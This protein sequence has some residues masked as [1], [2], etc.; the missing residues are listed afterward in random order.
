MSS[1]W[2]RTMCINYKLG[3][4]LICICAFSECFKSFF[5]FLNGYY[6]KYTKYNLETSVSFTV[7]YPSKKFYVGF[8]GGKSATTC[9]RN[10]HW[11][12]LG[13]HSG[14]SCT[15]C[16]GISR[17]YLPNL[18]EVFLIK[19]KNSVISHHH[20]SPPPPCKRL[21][22]FWQ[23]QVTAGR[24]TGRTFLYFV[25]FVR[26]SRGLIPRSGLREKDIKFIWFCLQV[27]HKKLIKS[28]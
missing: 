21:W 15:P 18:K 6:T 19:R 5:F 14:H 11:H 24:G 10:W 28:L 17:R 20:H 23:G 9:I 27:A 8:K 13:E 16:S 26:F 7:I 1:G 4:D 22:R 12:W 25:F 3:R 2:K